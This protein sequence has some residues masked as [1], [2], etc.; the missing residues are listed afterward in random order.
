MVKLLIHKLA[1]VQSLVQAKTS[2]GS[3]HRNSHACERAV[4]CG[5]DHF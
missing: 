1:L 5:G 4:G 3:Y 2:V